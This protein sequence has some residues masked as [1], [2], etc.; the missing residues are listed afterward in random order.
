[1][2]QATVKPFNWLLILFWS[3][4]SATLGAMYIKKRWLTVGGFFLAGTIIVSSAYIAFL[5][6]WIIPVFAP[7]LT[8]A[9]AT[10]VSIV[11]VLWR[12]LRLSYQKLEDYAR[13]LEDKVQERTA[14]LAQANA[15]IS[16]LNEKLQQDNLRMSAELD[17]L[18]QMQQMILPK[19]E[20]L[21]VIEGLDIAGF[22][23]AADEVGGDYYDVLYTDDVVTLGIGDVT[24]HGLE[25]GLLML[26]TQTAVRLLKE[27]RE[28]DSVRFLDTLNRTLYKNVQRMNSDKSLTLVIL[29]YSQG[30]IS[31]SG[32]HEETI[33]VRNNREIERIDTIDLGFPIALDDDI[34]DFISH[35]TIQ[36]QP[37]D[38][39]VLY[40]DGITEAKD[41]NKNQYGIE[42]LCEI[43]SQNWHKSASE[44]KDAVILDV[45]RHIG[46]QKVFDDITLVVL[47]RQ[48][49]VL[50]N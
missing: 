31:I 9:S 20:E 17:I 23:E 26:M 5:G 22:M 42:Q 29:N 49:E 41:I 27:I 36:L 14:Q 24:G 47:K 38:G 8:V 7:M 48:E 11:H 34:A 16:I 19:P 6:G 2:L 3:G 4:Y 50:L 15:E 13:T 35:T 28:S 1:M 40:T 45:R 43:I 21:E 39:I 44:I 32:Q 30:Q 12:N 46:T 10:I 33:L 37:G 25:S 18:R